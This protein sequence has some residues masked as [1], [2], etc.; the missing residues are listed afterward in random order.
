MGSTD[1][2]E[3]EIRELVIHFFP[4]LAVVRSDGVG[5]AVLEVVAQ[6]DLRDGAQRLLDRG[7]LYQ[8]IGA[9]ALLLNHPLDAAHL[10]FD[11]AKARQRALLELGVDFVCVARL[12]HRPWQRDTPRGY[13]T[14]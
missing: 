1:V 10:P 9:I 6:E 7:E 3:E 11:T 5:G 12:G 4:P 14:C 2:F 8:R 13:F